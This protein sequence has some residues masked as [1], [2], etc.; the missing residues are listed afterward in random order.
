MIWRYLDIAV[1]CK[2]NDFILVLEYVQWCT[3]RLVSSEIPWLSTIM[4]YCEILQL[5]L[6]ANFTSENVNILL[7]IF[8]SDIHY[9]KIHCIWLATTNSLAGHVQRC[10]IVYIANI[11]VCFALFNEVDSNVEIAMAAVKK[12]IQNWSKLCSCILQQII[13]VV[14]ECL[15]F[16]LVETSA[17]SRNRNS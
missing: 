8:Q 15:Y 9:F 5:Q 1:S 11:A 4:F 16:N 3:S 17:R 13:G 14:S 6:P 12:K 10:I 7:N 2:K